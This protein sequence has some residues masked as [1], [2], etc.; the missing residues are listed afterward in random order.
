[1]RFHV[2]GA[3]RQSGQERIIAVDV[4]D[5]A[6]AEA[7][8]NRRGLLVESVRPVNANRVAKAPLDYQSPR[9]AQSLSTLAMADNRHERV[10]FNQAGFVVTRTRLIFRDTI[11]PLANVAAVS[12]AERPSPAV[13]RGSGCIVVALIMAALAWTAN[14]DSPRDTI[15]YFVGA[16]ALGL[17]AVGVLMI[18]MA[19]KF[20]IARIQ[21]AGGANDAL[22]SRDRLLVC[23]LVAA[24][25]AAII[26]RG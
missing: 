2:S 10:Y 19:R 18:L 1:M 7:E 9:A 22:V 4:P 20:Y 17:G 6:A 14:Q 8:A 5:A 25:N 23:A 3:D 11:Y 16:L 15:P 26:D 21:T 24:V 13:G 12:I